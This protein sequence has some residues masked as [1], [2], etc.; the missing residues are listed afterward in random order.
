MLSWLS[1]EY[2]K[3][4]HRPPVNSRRHARSPSSTR[5]GAAQP[6]DNNGQAECAP[7]LRPHTLQ[8]PLQELVKQAKERDGSLL[9]G[10]G[11]RARDVLTA[12]AGEATTGKAASRSLLPWQR[13]L[14]CPEGQTV[15]RGGHNDVTAARNVKGPFDHSGIL[16][17]PCPHL[18]Q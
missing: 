12:G 10:P 17:G 16:A 7:G 13:T 4:L 1:F 11:F 15:A 3:S 14:P 6:V 8:G 5:L 18:T 2:P 9:E